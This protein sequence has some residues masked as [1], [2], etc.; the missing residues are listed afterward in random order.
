[1][2]DGDLALPLASALQRGCGSRTKGRSLGHRVHR[3]LLACEAGPSPA[4]RHTTQA[5]R[6][7]ALVARTAAGAL[8]LKESGAAVAAA[9]VLCDECVARWCQ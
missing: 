8:A 9:D 4:V 3:A 6:A 2:R 5:R 7:F 1:M